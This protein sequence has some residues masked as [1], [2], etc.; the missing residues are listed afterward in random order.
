[1]A[2]SAGLHSD[3]EGLGLSPFSSEIRRRLWWHLLT[4]DGRAGEDYGLAIKIPQLTV[5]DVGLPLNIDD[6]DLNPGL[7][8][9]PPAKSGWTP[10]TF[11][12]IN[13]DLVQTMQ[14]LSVTIASSS[15]SSPPSEAQRIRII[16]KV[17]M[18]VDSRLQYCNPVIPQHRL[19]LLCSRFLLRKLDF[20]SR[21]QFLCLRNPGPREDFATE[22]ILIEALEILEPRL[23]DED[24]LLMQFAWAR[25]AYPQYHIAM[26]VLWHLCLRPE[27]PS[28]KRAWRAVEKFFAE[29]HWNGQSEDFGVNFKV[30][31]A[32]RVKAL[33][34]RQQI[35]IP[36]S[37]VDL[38]ISGDITG[39]EAGESP[40]RTHDDDPIC[41]LG[42]VGSGDLGFDVGGD[43][44]PNW[45]TLAQAFQLK[46]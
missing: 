37:G 23:D 2:E 12:L 6:A 28:V 7:V 26:Y 15:R 24:E 34:L 11:S 40:S 4:R 35:V 13:I 17:S 30:L 46:P 9:L 19:T 8:T 36:V 33:A 38:H 25:K 14:E 44:W 16:A 1:M 31:T 3:G 29:E 43:D 41:L 22:E 39:L 21:Q 42:N 45:A 20:I 10:M 18:K 27:G 5:S 32:L